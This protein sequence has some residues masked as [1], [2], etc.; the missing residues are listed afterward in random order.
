[1]LRCSRATDHLN[2]RT[3]W[4]TVRAVST[5][6][7]MLLGGAPMK[8]RGTSG[9]ISYPSCVRELVG[10]LSIE[11]VMGHSR[12][13]LPDIEIDQRLELFEALERMQVEPLVT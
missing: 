9:G 6:R 7:F 12:V 2:P 4:L 8:G 13:V 5:A 10:C 11:S 1:M 3:G